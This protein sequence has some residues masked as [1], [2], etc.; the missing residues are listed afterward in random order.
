MPKELKN[1][2]SHRYR[3]VNKLREFL[4]SK[5]EVSDLKNSNSNQKSNFVDNKRKATD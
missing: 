3:A 5:L 1:T 4:L 2:I